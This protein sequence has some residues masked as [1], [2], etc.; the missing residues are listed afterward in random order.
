MY[1]T[2]SLNV[3]INLFFQGGKGKKEKGE[4][5]TEEEGEERVILI[6]Y[7]NVLLQCSKE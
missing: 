5:R 6:Y 3:L 1:G 7:K 4:E 2:K